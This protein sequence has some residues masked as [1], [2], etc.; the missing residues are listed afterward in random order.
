MPKAEKVAEAKAKSAKKS[1]DEKRNEAVA[2]GVSFAKGSAVISPRITEKA[3]RLSEN[4]IYAFNVRKDANARQIAEAV[5]TA[6][7]VK[8][9]KVSVAPVKSKSMFSR[10]KYGKTVAGKKAYVYLKKGDKI[11]FV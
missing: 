5:E 3:A 10:G 8:P 1:Q 6:Y 2:G 7:K 9:V 11:E 4:G